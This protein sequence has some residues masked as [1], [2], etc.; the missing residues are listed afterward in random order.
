MDGRGFLPCRAEKGPAFNACEYR[1]P[2]CKRLCGKAAEPFFSLQYRQKPLCR[3]AK[4]IR[5]L[6]RA[7]AQRLGQKV[8]VDIVD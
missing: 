2:K 5:T 1:F 4:E 6:V 7:Y 3:I 8:S